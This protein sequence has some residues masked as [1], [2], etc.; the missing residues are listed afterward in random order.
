[1]SPWPSC[2]WL[3]FWKGWFISVCEALAEDQLCSCSPSVAW[4]CGLLIALWWC[5]TLQSCSVSTPQHSL[6]RVTQAQVHRS[7]L[8]GG[9]VKALWEAS[10]LRKESL[11]RDFHSINLC[12]TKN[13][14]WS[15]SLLFHLPNNW[16][17]LHSWIILFSC[18]YQMSASIV[19][20]DKMLLQ[21][22]TADGSTLGPIL[23]SV[24]ETVKEI[25]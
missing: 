2:H 6:C 14:T 3:L 5:L 20:L 18:S 9:E 13:Q 7:C 10:G 4:P 24:L 1:M 12:N 21:K 16:A 17:A 15:Q 19:R 23:V 22:V 8:V 25:N 11:S